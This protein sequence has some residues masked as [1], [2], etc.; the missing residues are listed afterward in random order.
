MTE[1]LKKEEVEGQLQVL[2]NAIVEEESYL[3]TI[4]TEVKN[5]REK[6]RRH[7]EIRDRLQ[8]ELKDM[9]YE[10][11]GVEATLDKLKEIVEE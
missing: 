1:M 5:L 11:L 10:L 8:K 4:K 2:K 6:L 7:R 9:K 3:R